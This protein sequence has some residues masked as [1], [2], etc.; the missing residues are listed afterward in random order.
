ME[1]FVWAPEQW[2]C[3]QLTWQNSSA[4]KAMKLEFGKNEG[5]N[6][7]HSSHFGNVDS[8]DWLWKV[9]HLKTLAVSLSLTFQHF[10]TQGK[11]NFNVD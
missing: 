4:V 6:E 9:P 10:P 1:S 8:K 3:D 7:V 11:R 2:L 5:K